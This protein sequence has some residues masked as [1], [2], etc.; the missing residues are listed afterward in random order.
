MP[1]TGQLGT[2]ASQLANIQLGVGEAAAGNIYEQSP[3]NSFN[4]THNVAVQKIL[5][6]L[7]SQTLTLTHVANR[8]IP[9]SVSQTLTITQSAGFVQDKPASNTITFG[10]TVAVQKIVNRLVV[11]G[12]FVTQ[13]RS[14]NYKLRRNV[15]HSLLSQQVVGYRVRPVY[16]NITFAHSTTVSKRKRVVHSLTF[17]QSATLQIRYGRTV[18]S[19][20]QPFQA[21]ARTIKVRKTVTQPFAITQLAVGFNVKGVEQSFAVTHSATYT[22]SKFARNTLDLTQTVGLIKVFGRSVSHTLPLTHDLSRTITLTRSASNVI[23]YE[24]FVR[25]TKVLHHVASSAFSM[26]SVGTKTPL[27]RSRSQTLTFT[28]TAT[29]VRVIRRTV[30]QQL[31]LVSNAARLVTYNRSLSSALSF[32]AYRDVPFGINQRDVIRLENL[33]VIRLYSNSLQVVGAFYIEDIYG[34]KSMSGGQRRRNP[35]YVVLSVP[36]RTI[37][38]PA[39]EFGDGEN[40]EGIFS[41]RRAMDGTV[42]TYVK[43]TNRG[44]LSYRFTLSLDKSEELED[45]IWR[46][47]SDVMTLVNWKN[48][49]WKV[50]LQKNP[51]ELTPER[52][53]INVK[54]AVTVDLD[55][56]GIKLN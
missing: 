37:V 7:V 46:Y 25:K 5:S 39:P 15:S 20:F 51:I 35:R 13:S 45:F 27:S 18:N 21:V 54:E 22:L 36:Q 55:F 53:W 1:F 38:L 17:S 19:L 8:E 43:T 29:R 3:S 50:Q 11:H 32:K 12:F 10:Q 40:N 30:T 49:I 31:N 28:N 16:Q 44:K 52:R 47:N 14:L 2:S 42:R 34:N 33:N 56:E 4:V 48:E 6:K 26:T 24:H 23:A 9:R 41:L